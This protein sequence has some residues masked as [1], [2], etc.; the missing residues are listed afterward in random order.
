MLNYIIIA[1]S[2]VKRGA[3]MEK[4]SE[5]MAFSSTINELEVLHFDVF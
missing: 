2:F 5:I 3:I 1:A 4:T